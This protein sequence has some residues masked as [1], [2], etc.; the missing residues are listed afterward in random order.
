M[1]G[2]ERDIRGKGEGRGKGKGILEGN[3]GIREIRGEVR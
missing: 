1:K 3:H 2:K